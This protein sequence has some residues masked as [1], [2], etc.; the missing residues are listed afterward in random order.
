MAPQLLDHL[1]ASTKKP[2]TTNIL[3]SEGSAEPFVILSGSTVFLA[4]ANST[5]W[6]DT[7]RL[8]QTGSWPALCFPLWPNFPGLLTLSSLQSC[9]TSCVLFRIQ[10][11]GC[12]PIPEGYAGYQWLS[13]RISL[14]KHKLKYKI[15]TNFKMVMG[16]G[17]A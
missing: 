2:C 17:R 7:A 9:C 16:A 6:A 8:E 13:P 5:V 10:P 4:R 11:G 14:K 15:I 12:L 3:N 1:K